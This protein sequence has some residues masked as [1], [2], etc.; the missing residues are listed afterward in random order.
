MYSPSVIDFCSF[1][2]IQLILLVS[3]NLSSCIYIFHK[4]Q[5]HRNGRR[6]ELNNFK[7][8]MEDPLL[9]EDEQCTTGNPKPT[10][11][12]PMD[13]T[14]ELKNV[15]SMAAPMA[16]VTVAQFLLP[17]ISVMVAGHRG[18]LQLSGVALATSFANVSG[19]SIMVIT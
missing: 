1:F 5:R 4:S 10:P 15:S 12:W 14:A 6:H 17:L 9:P 2:K 13:F 8:L 7:K 18:E 16:T 19:F 11:T 3:V